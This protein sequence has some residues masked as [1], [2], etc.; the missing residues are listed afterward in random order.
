MKESWNVVHSWI[1]HGGKKR[2]QYLLFSILSCV[3]NKTLAPARIIHAAVCTVSSPPARSHC[4]DL[5]RYQ[6]LAHGIFIFSVT[7]DCVGVTPDWCSGSD[8]SWALTAHKAI[9]KEIILPWGWIFLEL[10]Q[11]KKKGY[12]AFRIV[13][14][15]NSTYTWHGMY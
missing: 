3:N 11:L 9:S 7:W 13:S 10:Y 4:E 14:P 15:L 2:K 5:G 6:S 8:C 12:V 1:N